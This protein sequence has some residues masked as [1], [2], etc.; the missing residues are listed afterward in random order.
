VSGPTSPGQFPK[1]DFKRGWANTER[2]AYLCG[3]IF[4]RAAYAALDARQR[5][6]LELVPEYRARECDPAATR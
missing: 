4:D 1:W 6:G 3:R 2:P 5:I